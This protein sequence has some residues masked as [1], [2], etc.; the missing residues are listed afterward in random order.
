MSDKLVRLTKPYSKIYM[1]GCFA[2]STTVLPPTLHPLHCK[3]WVGHFK[4]SG[5][6]FAY[7]NILDIYASKGSPDT[8]NMSIL[9]FL[10]DTLPKW[11]R[12]FFVCLGHPLNILVTNVRSLWA[13]KHIPFLQVAYLKLPIRSWHIMTTAPF[14]PLMLLFLRQN[15]VDLQVQTDISTSNRYCEFLEYHWRFIDCRPTKFCAMFVR[16]LKS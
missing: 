1:Y 6:A 9:F 8:N 5:L 14:T 3:I 16:S 15:F 10:R 13:T 11:G 2:T 12:G 4:A 7:R